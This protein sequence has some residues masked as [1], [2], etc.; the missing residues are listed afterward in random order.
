MLWW[1]QGSWLAAVTWQAGRGW[2]EPPSEAL[3]SGWSEPSPGLARLRVGLLGS[4]RLISQGPSSWCQ[5]LHSS[6]DGC[7]SRLSHQGPCVYP[8]TSGPPCPFLGRQEASPFPGQELPALHHSPP[9]PREPKRGGP[10]LP[11]RSVPLAHGA[12]NGNN[13]SKCI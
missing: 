2:V 1:P 10:F 4:L 13:H 7:P 11:G 5:T 8:S 3:G 6:G 12:H 9:P